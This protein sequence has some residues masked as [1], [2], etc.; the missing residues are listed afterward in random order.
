MRLRTVAPDHDSGYGRKQ[1][2]QIGLGPFNQAKLVSD[3][4]TPTHRQALH[5][6]QEDIVTNCF[7]YGFLLGSERGT[8][9]ANYSVQ[10]SKQRRHVKT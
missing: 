7:I 8:P 1:M 5:S 3:F 6:R 4:F 2:D 9:L 10:A